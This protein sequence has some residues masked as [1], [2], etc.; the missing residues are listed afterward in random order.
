MKVADFAYDARRS[1]AEHLAP[2]DV[3][4]RGSF[5]R[6]DHDE[7]SDVD[8][9]SRVHAVLDG[10][11]FEDLEAFLVGRY[12]PALVRYDPEFE[13]DVCAQDVRFSFRRLPVYWRLD[14]LVHSDRAAE[15]KFPHPFPPWAQGT[16][17]LMNVIWALKWLRRGDVVRAEE[18]L[19]AAGGKLGVEPLG[20]MADQVRAI[21]DLLAA[22][23]DVDEA[24]HTR[25][26]EAAR[27]R[28]V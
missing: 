13:S 23:D 21:L 6:G 1:V 7:F 10:R 2:A 27:E 5:A 17:A 12:G 25:T 4:F 14:L 26:C 3:R 22:R 20:S 18:Q 16:S 28:T 19:A 9:E 15:Q 11:F 8:L 24:L